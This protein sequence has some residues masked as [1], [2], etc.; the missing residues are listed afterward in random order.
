VRPLAF[1][2]DMAKLGLGHV[3]VSIDSLNPDTAE[4]LRA[5]TDV[6]QLAAMTSALASLFPGLT[7]S[8]V[9]SRVNL[10]ELPSLLEEIH[11]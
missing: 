1:Y 7:A 4:R 11:A 5:R 10:P 2:R 6:D 3:S 9:L 8:I